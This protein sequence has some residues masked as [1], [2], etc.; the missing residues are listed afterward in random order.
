MSNHQLMDYQL[1]GEQRGHQS[2]LTSKQIIR[3]SDGLIGG[4]IGGQSRGS[5]TGTNWQADNQVD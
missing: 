3:Q 1:I 4:K 2:G 5:F